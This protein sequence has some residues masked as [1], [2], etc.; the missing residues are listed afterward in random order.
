LNKLFTSVGVYSSHSFVVSVII[1]I[2]MLYQHPQERSHSV[3]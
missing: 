2:T 1:D 3:V